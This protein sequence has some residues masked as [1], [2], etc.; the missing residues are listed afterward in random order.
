MNGLRRFAVVAMMVAVVLPTLIGCGPSRERM[1]RY[2]YVVSADPGIPGEIEVDVVGVN[3]AGG[4]EWDAMDVNKYFLP[5]T[6]RRANEIKKTLTLSQG[7][8]VATLSKTDPI[9]NEWL[10][11]NASRNDGGIGA[12]S[13]YFVARM[14]QPV[15]AT[16][17]DTRL[18]SVPLSQRRWNNGQEINITLSG[19]G[20]GLASSMKPVEE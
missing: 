3:E 8:R 5:G 18:L 2:T 15:S 19:S 7:N 4:L 6:P 13:V 10:G 14:A 17:R 9:W 11:E 20:L 16:S 1:G 12:R